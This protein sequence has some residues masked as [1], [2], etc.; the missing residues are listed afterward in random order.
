MGNN[1]LVAALSGRR[2]KAVKSQPQINVNPTDFI[3]GIEGYSSTTYDDLGDERTRKGKDTIGPGINIEGEEG[4]L[5]MTEIGIPLDRAI[6]IQNRIGEID[7]SEGEALFK[8]AS[9]SAEGFVDRFL[10]RKGKALKDHQKLSL[11]SLAYNT[12]EIFGP[13]FEK[14]FSQKNLSHNI[15]AD[16]IEFNNRVVSGELLQGITKRRYLEAMM[17]RGKEPDLKWVNHLE[18]VGPRQ[19]NKIKKSRATLEREKKRLGVTR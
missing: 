7:D 4:L 3:I 11:V 16:K 14:M 2:Q 19:W 18:T 15:I 9:R 1:K 12:R 6:N 5:K 10:T 17:Y 13:N 8:N